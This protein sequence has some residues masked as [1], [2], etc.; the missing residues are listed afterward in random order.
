MSRGFFR[1]TAIVGLT[2]LLSRITGL[3]R[4]VVYASMVPVAAL[5]VFAETAPLTVAG[6]TDKNLLVVSRG[7]QVI[8]APRAFARWHRRRRGRSPRRGWRGRLEHQA[9]RTGR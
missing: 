2:T 9:T 5:E 8:D 7:K 4:D 6:K 3:A 1:S